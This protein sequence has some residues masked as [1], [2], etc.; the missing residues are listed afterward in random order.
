MEVMG[1]T[2]RNVYVFDAFDAIANYGGITEFLKTS[3]AAVRHNF[4]KYGVMDDRVFFQKGLFKDT[5]PKFKQQHPDLQLAV[6]RVDGNFYGEC[7]MH[8]GT[9]LL[10]GSAPSVQRCSV[11]SHIICGGCLLQHLAAD[12]DHACLAA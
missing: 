11:T 3:E 2:D 9:M 12:V 1:V 10:Q 7:C 8:V 4:D 6:L 5:L